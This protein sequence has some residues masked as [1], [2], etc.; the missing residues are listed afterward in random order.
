MPRHPKANVDN[1]V[2]AITHTLLQLQA[3]L[4]DAPTFIMGDLNNCKPGTFTS[5]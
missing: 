5:M 4:P 3:M 1:A 2:R